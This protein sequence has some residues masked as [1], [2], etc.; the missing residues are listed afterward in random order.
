MTAVEQISAI[1]NVV[2][3]QHQSSQSMMHNNNIQQQQRPSSACS[4]NSKSQT[5]NN[6]S[7]M[8]LFKLL[9][10]ANLNQYL[11]MFTEQGNFESK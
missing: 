5:G 9:E 8:D 4:L 6:K 11:A 7:E 2:A 10:R 1:M 3:T